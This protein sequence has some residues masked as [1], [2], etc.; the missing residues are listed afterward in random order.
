MEGLSPPET[1]MEEAAP[2]C[3]QDVLMVTIVQATGEPMAST[4]RP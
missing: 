2:K 4:S 3:I 1:P